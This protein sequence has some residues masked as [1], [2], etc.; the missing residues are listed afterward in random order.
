MLDGQYESSLVLASF[1]VAI[2]ASYTALNLVERVSHS[3]PSAARWWIAGGAFAMGT[4]IW[5]MHF[6]GMLAFRLPIALG[7]DFGITLLSW[8]IPVLVS[9][10]ALWQLRRPR[11]DAKHL[12]VSALLLGGGIVAM[13]YAGMHAMRM[14]PG[15]AY[16]LRLVAASVAIAIAAAGASLWIAF[17]LRNR[18]P[19]VWRFRA[20][21]AVVM[22]AAIVGMHYTGMAAA[23]FPAGSVCL[24]ATG[25]F[26][27]SELASLVIVATFAVLAIA[28]L[29]SVFD[30][31]LEVHSRAADKRRLELELESAARVEA[32][33]L[34]ALK[35][36]FL[37]TLSHELRTPLN[38]VLGWVQLLRLKRD[39]AT[40]QKALETIER[41]ARLQAKLIEDLLDMSRI[42][43]GK[44]RLE[45]EAVDLAAVVEA[46][47]ETAKPAAI[48]KQIALD[49]FIEGPAQQVVGDASRL[50][51]I[52]WN[53][54]SNAIK[55]TPAGGRVAVRVTQEDGHVVAVVEDTGSGIDAAFLPYVF[56]RFRQADASTTRVHGGLGIGL[57]IV[58]QLVELHG[59]TV[60][61]SSRGAGQG[62]TFSVRLP[63]AAEADTPVPIWRAAADGAVP[64]QRLA[65]LDLSGKRILVVDDEAD[66]R[67]MLGQLLRECRAEVVLAA[68]AEEALQLLPQHRPHVLVSDIGMPGVDGFELIRRVRSTQDPDVATIPAM[69]LSAFARAEDRARASRDGYDC[70][71][72]KP[73]DAGEF[74]AA[75]AVLTRQKLGHLAA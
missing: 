2:L 28:L 13:H 72:A 32:E 52:L 62:A 56:D 3:G 12:A 16:D 24:A 58:R 38:A 35:D 46:A 20:I 11:P 30:A 64:R 70:Y 66:A 1:L 60:A 26:Q 9:A 71:L 25:R 45:S 23:G 49:T 34:G 48:A 29:T 14:D 65:S 50:H 7:Y 19:H 41:N 51:Q 68:G 43:A 4:G 55:F 53:L 40:L 47:I 69:V 57:S 10:L 8:A 21:A 15:I 33:R 6:V 61:V 31:R 39:E 63:L 27:L 75:M 17:R 73:V 42:V 36:Q 5:S 54:L 67:Q 18:T 44:V 22:G 37:A 74:L 59:G